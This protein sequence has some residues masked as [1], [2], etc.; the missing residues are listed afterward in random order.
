MSYAKD[1]IIPK[2]KGVFRTVFL[3]V[4]Q[5][6]STLLVIPDGQG[7]KYMLVDTNTDTE[8]GGINIPKL[9]E[10]L[11]DDG[12][13][14]FVNTHPHNDHLKGVKEI[15]AIV[16]IKQVWHSG[17]KPSKNHE[18]A[19]QELKNIIEHIG[20]GNVF[21]LKGSTDENKLDDAYVSLGGIGFNVLA[22]AE[23]V[24]DDIEDEKPEDRYK[25]IHEQCSVIKFFYGVDR[26]CILIT[27]DADKT[28]WQKYITD[29]HA[30]RL[31]ADVFSAPHHGSIT[32]FKIDNEEAYEEHMEYIRPSHLVISAPKKS[33]SPHS[34]PDDDAIKIYKKYIDETNIYH[35]GKNRECLI[36]DIY[37]DGDLDIIVDKDLVEHYGFSEE[38]DSGKYLGASVGAITSRMDRKPMG[39][40]EV[41]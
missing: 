15:N 21:L 37:E 6:E 25:R 19:Y 29:Y 1:I 20:N 12:L 2:V 31:A 17:H 22:P 23:Y 9:L 14:I 32:F 5:G 16:P 36:V 13:D 30:E 7:W 8:R 26:K 35:L 11:L 10:D 3:Y 38:K 40:D 18:E 39:R 34:H 28:A 27:G 24:A 41:V 4:G 33:E